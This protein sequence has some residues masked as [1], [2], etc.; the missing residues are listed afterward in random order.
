V[1]QPEFVGNRPRL[2]DHDAMRLKHGIDVTGR[3]ARVVGQRHCRTA[4]NVEIGDNA[5]TGQSIPEP[6]EGTLDRGTV[7]EWIV[8]THATFNSWAAT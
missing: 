7:Q 1:R 4:E 3:P 8:R 5:T 6:A 2:I